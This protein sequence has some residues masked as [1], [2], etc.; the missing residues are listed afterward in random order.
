VKTSGNIKMTEREFRAEKRR[1]YK[2]CPLCREEKEA[3]WWTQMLLTYEAHLRDEC[4]KDCPLCREEKEA[5]E[6]G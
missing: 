5:E 4:Y 1:H 6:N 3:E 2:D